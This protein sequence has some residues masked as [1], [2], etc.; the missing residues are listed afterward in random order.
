MGR[1]MGVDLGDVRI[2]IALSDETQFLASGYGVIKHEGRRKSVEKIGKIIDEYDVE[3]V[4]MG[5]PRNMNGTYG[6]M[7]EKVKRFGE[8]LTDQ[9]GVR[10]HYQDERL[11][12][13]AAENVLIQGGL[14]REK[15]RQVVDQVAATVILQAYLDGKE[16]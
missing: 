13:V 9:L 11:S 15:R 12:T 6:P 1:L 8:A 7:A 5:L 10:V 16:D 14:T 2:G 4:I 3:A